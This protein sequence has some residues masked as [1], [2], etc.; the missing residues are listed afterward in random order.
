MC[1]KWCC[2]FR[3]SH[4][5]NYSGL[6]TSWWRHR[7]TGS[8]YISTNLSPNPIIFILKLIGVKYAV[9]WHWLPVSSFPSVSTSR[10][11]LLQ[12]QIMKACVRACVWVGGRSWCGE[13]VEGCERE[14]GRCGPDAGSL[15]CGPYQIK[16]RYWIDCG[17]PG[18]PA[19]GN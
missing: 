18:D 16:Q 1:I 5:V 10:P 6:P 8:S 15:S 13:Q 14:L 7:L 17:R 3:V 11:N 12:M 2:L 4:N 9:D 19:S